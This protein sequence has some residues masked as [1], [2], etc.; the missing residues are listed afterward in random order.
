[1]S[2]C[3]QE[4]REEDANNKHC[5]HFN[6]STPLNASPI[7]DITV[8]LRT[9]YRRIIN[10]YNFITMFPRF[11]NSFDYISFNNPLFYPNPILLVHRDYL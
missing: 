7:D 8:I 6:I 11:I 1:V 3:E 10:P 5:S 2:E 4:K 9:N